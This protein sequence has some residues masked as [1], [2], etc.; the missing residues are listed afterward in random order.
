MR[1]SYNEGNKEVRII[2][3]QVEI[4]MDDSFVEPKVIILTASMT[5]EV[6]K[7]IQKLSENSPQILSGSKDERI[8]VLEP[9]ELI[10]IYA[11]NSKVY[12]VTERGEYT[13]KLRLYEVEERLDPDQFVRISNSEIIN[14]KKV[15]NFDLSFSGTIC[16]EL[17]NGTS[18]FT[19][20]RYVAKIKKILGI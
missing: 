15:R 1:P 13:L 9:G 18:T 3:M 14:L 2:T 16:V 6:S 10:R 8:E 5:E 4:R 11:A 17:A 12:A 7:M 20:R 19:S